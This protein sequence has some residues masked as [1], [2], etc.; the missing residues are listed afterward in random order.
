M[1]CNLTHLFIPNV[2]LGRG[3]ITTVARH[4]CNIEK[5]SSIGI[6]FAAPVFSNGP[7]STIHAPDASTISRLV[8]Q[9]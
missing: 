5:A 3:L 7:F 8:I 4:N 9:Q 1:L 2:S 6:M